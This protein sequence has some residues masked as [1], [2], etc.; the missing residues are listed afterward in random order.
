MFIAHSDPLSPVAAGPLPDSSAGGLMLDGPRTV[1]HRPGRLLGVVRDTCGKADP[2]AGLP[3][4]L[5]D[6]HDEV[7]PLMRPTIAPDVRDN[8]GDGAI[9][10]YHDHPA[11]GGHG[12]P[13]RPDR[14]RVSSK[15]RS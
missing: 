9:A 12:N 4:D 1:I 3:F 14:P 13:G 15:D 11:R 8:D 2:H 10:P 6:R 7:L 5:G